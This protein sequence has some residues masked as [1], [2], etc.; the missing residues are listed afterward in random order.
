MTSVMFC[1]VVLGNLADD[2]ARNFS[3]IANALSRLKHLNDCLVELAGQDY[4]RL[5]GGLSKEEEEMLATAQKH[6][7][8]IRDAGIN[9]VLHY[10]DEPTSDEPSRLRLEI[11]GSDWGSDNP[12]YLS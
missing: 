12:L 1:A 9:V 7:E 5:N 4:E 10:C 6:A 3:K 8:K 11:P 2:N